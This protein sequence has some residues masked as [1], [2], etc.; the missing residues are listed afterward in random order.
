VSATRLIDCLVTTDA[1]ADVFSDAS[2]LQAMLDFEASLARAEA[3]AGII[4]ARAA[5]II[6]SSARADDFDAGAIARA[7]RDSASPAIPLV[8]ALTDRVHAADKTAA[9]FVHWG[10]TS[11]DVVD[12]ALVILLKRAKPILAADHARLASALRSQSEAHASTVMLG[13]TLLQPAVPITFGL[14]AATWFSVA[15]GAWRRLARACD[16]AMI[17]QFGGASGTLAALGEQ[18]PDVGRALAEDL[19]LAPS[20]PWH[21]DR[22]RLAAVV[23]TCGMYT[24]ALGKIA[25]DVALLMQPEIGELAEPGGGSSAMPH[26]RN[27]AGCAIALAAA[28]RLPGIVGGFLTGMVQ[29]HER[30]V[31]GWQAEWSAVADA[32]QATGSAVAAMAAAI[33]G[34]QVFPDRMR[35]NVEAM[36]GADLA[37]RATLVQRAGSGGHAGRLEDSLG[38]AE[39]IR[40]KLLFSR[41]G[42]N[43]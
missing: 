4:P 15:E 35:A 36:G 11:Q 27:P 6:G 41:A 12:T 34:L 21:T 33:E 10:A 39:A 29:E 14:K 19:G 22:G 5:E 13:R 25:R 2:V 9:P 8:A 32:V 16:D 31:G 18:G 1:L 20:L 24:A 7:A 17:V 40:R 38:S 43:A 30:A 42:D 37:E 28:A 26:K 23:T 3:G